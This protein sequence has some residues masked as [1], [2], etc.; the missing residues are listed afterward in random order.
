MKHGIKFLY[1]YENIN[2]IYLSISYANKQYFVD[3]LI[4]T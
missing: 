3:N 2:I 4:N 1:K